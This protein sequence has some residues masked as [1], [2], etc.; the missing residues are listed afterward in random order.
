MSDGPKITV[1]KTGRIRAPNL[2]DPQL[3]AIGEVMVAAQKARW[4][5]GLNADGVPAKKLSKRYFFIKK[6]YTRQAA[7]IRDMRMTGA[8]VEN[9]GLRRAANG[10]I[11][12]ENTTRETRQRA[13]RAQ[14]SEDM[15][16]FAASDQITVFKAAE[17]QYGEYL[18]KAWVP[19]G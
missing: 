2:A 16:G 18:K 14:K 10:V 13:T 4:D 17:T 9:F 15:I 3:R 11:R 8:T 12:A 19:L 7:P 1:K 6:K 5:D